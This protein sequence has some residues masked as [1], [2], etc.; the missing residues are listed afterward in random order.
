MCVTDKYPH[1][2]SRLSL[3]PSVSAHLG[4]CCLCHERAIQGWHRFIH[5]DFIHLDIISLDF[6][7][8]SPA[9]KGA[10]L[11]LVDCNSWPTFSPLTWLLEGCVK[12]TISI[13]EPLYNTTEIIIF[14]IMQA[15]NSEF[16]WPLNLLLS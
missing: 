6:N 14:C 12:S 15:A 5:L 3:A 10:N 11:D 1:I 9:K 13:Q 4:R 7:Q 8:I 2:S 16:T